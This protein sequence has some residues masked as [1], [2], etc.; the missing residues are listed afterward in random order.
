M[1]TIRIAITHTAATIH[2]IHALVCEHPDV[3]RE[4]LLYFSLSDGYET[5]INYLEGDPDVYERALQ[6]LEI[7]EYEVYPDGEDGCYSY[8]RDELDD[9]NK[10]LATAF[11]RDELAVVPPVE[12]LPDRR[13]LLTLVTTADEFQKITEE[14]PA[15]VSIDVLSID[16]A[17][18]AAGSTLTSTQRRAIETAWE[19]GYYEIP[20]TADL[21]AVAA[22]LDSAVSSVSDLLRRAHANLVAAELGVGD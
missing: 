1:R 20:R 6:D 8:L 19:L 4:L 21:E 7:D 12:Y 13:L 9:Y 17:P 15:E 3:H 22:E 16:S 18:R 2:P 5:A 14:I 10:S 11:R